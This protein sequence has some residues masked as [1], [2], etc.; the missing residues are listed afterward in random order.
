MN[1]RILTVGSLIP[2]MPLETPTVVSRETEVKKKSTTKLS[3]TIMI[4]QNGQR[5]D[6]VPSRGKLLLDAALEQGQDLDYKCRK[7]TCGRCKVK[8]V[9]GSSYLLPPNEMEQ[10]KLKDAL[11]EGYRLSCQSVFEI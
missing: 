1:R 10:Q 6:V 3:P 2:G 9:S 11:N 7:G 8:I 4:L 5:F